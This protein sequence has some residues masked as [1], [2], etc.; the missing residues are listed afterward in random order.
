MQRFVD[1]IGP[2]LATMQVME[3]NGHQLLQD[4]PEISKEVIQSF[5]S[6]IVNR[7][8]SSKKK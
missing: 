2:T 4:Q 1:V 6:W 3:T 8:Q 5:T 7:I